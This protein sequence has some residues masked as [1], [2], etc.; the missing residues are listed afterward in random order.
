VRN[1]HVSSMVLEAETNSLGRE[2]V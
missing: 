1:F 2:R